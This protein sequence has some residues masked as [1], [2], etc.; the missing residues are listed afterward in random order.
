MTRVSIVILNWNRAKDT[1]QCLLSIGKLTIKDY[2]LNVV[3]VDN[4][5]SDDS[6][7]KIRKGIKR[8]TGSANITSELV[9]N[10]TNLGFAGGNNVGIKHSLNHGA[11]FVLVLNNDTVVAKNLIRGLL[12]TASKYPNAGAISPKIY[13]AEGY[14]FHE[15]RYRK[16]ERGKVIWYAG[17]NIDWANVLGT[18]RG[19]DEVD[20][21]QYEKIH[22]TDFA[23][24]ACVLLRKQVLKEVGM[25]DERYYLYL[26][27]V[28]LSQ[29][30]KEK[31]WEI[32]YSPRGHL[33]HKV[34][35]SSGVGSDLNDYFITRNRLLFG[36]KY[37]PLRARFA[38]YKESLR[39]LTSGRE[40]QKKGV[41]DYYLRKFDRGSWKSS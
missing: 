14:E 18:N 21:G 28:D 11:D 29:R 37:A 20:E 38:L 12:K 40:W 19:V 15:S 26:E 16:A 24:G 36:M 13:F 6:V 32:L 5:S 23:T 10:K 7:D 22:K 3:V 1:I 39:L 17:G 4:A 2:T 41:I 27:D 25:F 35:Q 8:I 9:A 33:W 31:G 34:A 30:M